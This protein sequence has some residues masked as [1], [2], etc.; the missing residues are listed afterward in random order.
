M[1]R[2][3]KATST[4]LG[5]KN[6]F[7]EKFILRKFLRIFFL[8]IQEKVDGKVYLDDTICKNNYNYYHL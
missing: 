1:E 6:L 7:L 8:I 3:T 2:P 4:Y 5:N